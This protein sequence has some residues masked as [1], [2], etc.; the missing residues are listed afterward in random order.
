FPSLAACGLLG[1]RVLPQAERLPRLTDV[2]PLIDPDL[3]VATASVR[4]RRREGHRR[5]RRAGRLN[6][7]IARTRNSWRRRVLHVMVKLAV[8]ILCAPSVAV[9]VIVCCPRL[10]VCPD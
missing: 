8:P 7:L 10:N 1:G 4:C 9:S 5:P 6:R 3:T 2:F